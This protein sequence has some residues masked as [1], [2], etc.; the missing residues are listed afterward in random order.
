MIL[1]A[2]DH[3]AADADLG[4]LN[5]AH[6]V[7]R[8]DGRA[9]GYGRDLVGMDGGRIERDRPA[10][11]HGVVLS[12][13]VQRHLTRETDVPAARIGAHLATRRHGGE[14]KPPTRAED[15]QALSENRAQKIDL[16]HRFRLAAM[17]IE[18]RTRDG[19]PV[20]ALQR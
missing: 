3:G 6:C 20:I 14:L 15:R 11:V 17:N 19:E 8:G 1:H 18:R 16:A 7:R 13:G 2:P 9:G 10:R 12:S 5:I 4:G